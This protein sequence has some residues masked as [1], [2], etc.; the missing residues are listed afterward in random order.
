MYI[1]STDTYSLIAKQVC[2]WLSLSLSPF[3][4]YFHPSCNFG[5]FQLTFSFLAHPSELIAVSNKEYIMYAEA[6]H[7]VVNNLFL[8][9]PLCTILLVGCSLFFS[10]LMRVNKLVAP[11]LIHVIAI[12]CSCRDFKQTNKPTSISG[13]VITFVKFFTALFQFAWFLQLVQ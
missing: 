8:R 13:I 12:H 3:H 1:M 5:L 2:G 7:Y 6:C 4:N 10:T 11:W 9:T